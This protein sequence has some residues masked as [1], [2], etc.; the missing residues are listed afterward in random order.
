MPICGW[1]RLSSADER[2]PREWLRS[3]YACA[4]DLEKRAEE[5]GRLAKQ[6]TPHV[7][8]QALRKLLCY[9]HAITGNARPHLPILAEVI[10]TAYEVRHVRRR[11]PP[12]AG[13]LYKMLIRY[14]L[15]QMKK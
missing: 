1:L 8:A 11:K 9:V 3:M 4:D 13:S 12:T 5:L 7:K 2:F 14:V 10:A 6:K 15:P